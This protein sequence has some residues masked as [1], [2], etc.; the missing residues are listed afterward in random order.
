MKL[1]IVGT[2]VACFG[3]AA[4]ADKQD[5]MKRDWSYTR[6]EDGIRGTTIVEALR[7][8]VE[9]TSGPFAYMSIRQGGVD[10]GK[11]GFYLTPPPIRPICVSGTVL[12]KIGS[13]PAQEVACQPGAFTLSIDA[14]AVPRIKAADRVVLELG[15]SD[16]VPV[17]VTFDI[18]DLKM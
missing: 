17:Q 8:S 5:P 10:G 16:G 11:V 12:L 13:D 1:V 2:I 6:T 7:G 4:C 14:A 18:A 3:L 9:G 15:Q